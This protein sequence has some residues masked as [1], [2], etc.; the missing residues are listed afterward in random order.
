MNRFYVRVVTL[1]CVIQIGQHCCEAAGDDSPTPIRL[2]GCR[3]KPA[4]QVTIAINETGILDMIAREG[5]QVQA[6][7][8][9]ARL[10]DDLPRAALAVAEREATNTVEIKYSQVASDVA[11]LEHEQAQRVNSTVQGALT[12][13]DIRRRKLEL[14]QSISRIEQARYNQEVAV[15]KRNQAAIHLKAF[16]VTAPFSGTINKVLKHRGEATRQGDP[17]LELIN[18]RQVR[19]EGY[20]DLAQR[21]LVT[22][23]TMVRVEA[24]SPTKQD[25]SAPQ[26]H[27]KIVFVDSVVQPVT[28]QVRVWADIE[29]TDEILLPGQTAI[30]T[31][32]MKRNTPM[33]TG[34]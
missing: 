3:V 26:A 5:D 29:N 24:E 23:G 31:I 22:P 27:G 9:I 11:L 28:R 34:R 33:L 2:V 19:V 12:V 13:I 7:Q 20:L 32:V 8:E 16:R 10:H 25:P 4:D 1:I 14:D 18:T 15:L 17:V 6:G 21:R 30:V